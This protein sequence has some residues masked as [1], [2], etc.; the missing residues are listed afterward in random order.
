SGES[1]FF[2]KTG[3]SPWLLP[4]LI[5]PET[6]DA[7]PPGTEEA[8]ACTLLAEIEEAVQGA[9]DSMLAVK[10]S[11]AHHANLHRSPDPMFAIGNHIMFATAH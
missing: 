6:S 7:H 10:I 4:P 9:R 2:L 3:H 11:Q 1:P 5:P 8:R